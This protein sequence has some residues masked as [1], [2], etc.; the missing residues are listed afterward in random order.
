MKQT[1]S[2]PIDSAERARRQRY[3]SATIITCIA[4][5]VIFGVIHVVKLGANR[6]D[7][8]RDRATYDLKNEK[9]HIRAAGEDI[10]RHREHEEQQGAQR[11]LA[12]TEVDALLATQVWKELNQEV[13]VPAGE[14][15][16][17]TDSDRADLYD[18]PRHSVNLSA[19]YIDKYPVTVAQYA[20][21][22]SMKGQR[23]PL[24]WENGQIP[25][26]KL[27]HPVTMVSWHDSKA[28][29]AWQNKQLPSE[30][31]WEKAARGLNGQRWPWGERM[32][33]DA[34]NTYYSIG[35][36]TKVTRYKNGV[37]PLGVYDLA[38][39]VSEW[40][41]SDFIPYPGTQATGEVFQAKITAVTSTADSAMKVA[42]L[43]NVEGTFKVRRGGSW[44]SDPFSTSSYH[45][46]FSLP[47]YASDFFGFRCAR[48]KHEGEMQK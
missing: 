32:N 4:L 24:D 38:G 15:V 7:D 36:T 20:R 34:V 11:K 43:V 44:K 46:N 10:I 48:E 16:M 26:K 1:Y 21:F 35:S 45:R 33:A 47:H 29:C 5:A 30:A 18:T 31:Q 22:V 14:F 42:S 9:E 27:T 8:M 2:T 13:S 37:S 28:Y 17:G 19:Y 41:S 6:M 12:L 25:T 39:N 40:T 3:L 23:P